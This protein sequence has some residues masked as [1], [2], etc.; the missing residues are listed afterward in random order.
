MQSLSIL[1]ANLQNYVVLVNILEAVTSYAQLRRDSMR[2]VLIDFARAEPWGLVVDPGK[3]RTFALHPP[4]L[5][6]HVRAAVTR[7]RLVV[8]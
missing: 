2:A 8:T 4:P 3:Q 6:Q 5:A 7:A 1:I